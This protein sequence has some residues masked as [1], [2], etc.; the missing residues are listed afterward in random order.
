MNFGRLAIENAFGTLKNRWRILRHF[1]FRID[2]DAMIIVACCWLDNYYELWNEV[3]LYI[4]NIALYR[5]PLIKFGN[6]RLLVHREGEQ[7]KY[8]GEKLR[9]KFYNQW[10]L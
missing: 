5:N 1:N 9:K 7:A 10:I 2:R 4:A 6:A 3:E 8:E